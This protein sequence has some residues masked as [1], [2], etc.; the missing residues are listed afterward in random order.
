[1]AYWLPPPFATC[2]LPSAT[3]R[4]PPAAR[5]L[6]LTITYTIPSAAT[7]SCLQYRQQPTIYLSVISLAYIT[8]GRGRGGARVAAETGVL[9]ALSPLLRISYPTPDPTR[10]YRLSQSDPT[11]PNLAQTRPDPAPDRTRRGPPRPDPNRPDPT[12]PGTIP[13]HHTTALPLPQERD[14]RPRTAGERL[15]ALR[16][17]LKR[18]ENE[19]VST[20]SK[21]C[22]WLPTSRS[23]PPLAGALRQRAIVRNP[24]ISSSTPHP[25][26]PSTHR[27]Y[28][29]CLCLP[30]FPIQ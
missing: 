6:L 30:C 24:S 1:M 4:L 28:I 9:R 11:L 19:L 17:E 12:R 21:R 20:R 7:D 22:K 26:P 15:N 13:R 16:K 14:L 25:S 29:E 3:R 18:A 27:L 10:A 8:G 23:L 5:H 2:H